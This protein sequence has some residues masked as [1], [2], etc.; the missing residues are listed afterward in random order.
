MIN[1]F[2][3]VPAELKKYNKFIVKFPEHLEIQE[4]AIVKVSNPIYNGNKWE[5]IEFCFTDPIC[6]SIS[7]KLIKLINFAKKQKQKGESILF[8]IEMKLLD[9][10]DIVIETWNISVSE[11]IKID[12]GVFDYENLNDREPKLIIK[13]HNCKVLI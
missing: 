7:E 10:C 11:I 1:N 6:V 5:N 12:L 3:S 9:P 8:V 4:W 2:K 13:P